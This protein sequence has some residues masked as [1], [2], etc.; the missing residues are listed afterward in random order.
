VICAL[1]EIL[2]SNTD[3]AVM[4]TFSSLT[5]GVAGALYVTDVV[6]AF[7]KVPAPD[8]G[9]MDH[10]TPWFDGSLLTVAVS[11]SVPPAC[12]FP[13]PDTVICNVTITPN[14][15]SVSTSANTSIPEHFAP[16]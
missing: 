9:G 2:V 7:A 15:I 11:A 3:V 5:G 13:V 8:V 12:T 10:V 6:V 14:A 1:A 16:L 4:V